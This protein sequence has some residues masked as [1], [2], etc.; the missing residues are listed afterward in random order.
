MAALS[1][2]MIFDA[3][4]AVLL[5]VTIGY[6]VVLS[7]KMSAIRQS[8]EEL[9]SFLTDF[10]RAIS[11]AELSVEQLKALQ[12]DADAT[13][14][15]HIEQA[16]YIANDLSYLSDKGENVA[17]A[18]DGY[19]S[20]SRAVKQP[21]KEGAVAKKRSPTPVRGVSAIARQA[22]QPQ[23]QSR[24]QAMIEEVLTKISE[25]KESRSGD[26]V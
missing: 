14:N 3:A 5:L 2:E 26:T 23:K 19:I 11:R 15:A 10:T 16:Q 21:A 24:K 4:V 20:R 18:L 12:G 9:Q 17:R 1:M 7:R 8:R 22:S 6:C 13:L 25:R